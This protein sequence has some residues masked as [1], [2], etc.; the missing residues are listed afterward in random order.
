MKKTLYL[1]LILGTACKT[2][3]MNWQEMDFGSFK[4]KA[5][6]GWRGIKEQG[7][8]S[9]VGGLTDG[10]DTLE[11]E[12]GVYAGFSAE[13]DSGYHYATDTVNGL[14]A[15]IGRPDTEGKGYVFM[16]LVNRVE[17]AKFVI[18]GKE[19]QETATVLKIFKT[20]NF[21]N[22]DSNINPALTDDKFLHRSFQDDQTLYETH[23]VSCHNTIKDWEAPSIRSIRENRSDEWIRTFLADR[24][25]V[26]H[27]S[28]YDASLRR[29]DTR[30]PEQKDLT[31]DDIEMIIGF[32][33]IHV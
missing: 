25:A 21:P 1:L 12:Y 18:Y 14:T 3:P 22:S 26:K 27:D 2:A 33:K 19:I 24:H 6:L 32:I 5:P 16:F 30:C 10:R 13:Q 9:H 8:D 15:S 4:L 31:R 23:C 29:T 20:I 7:I 11:F 28:L 17:K